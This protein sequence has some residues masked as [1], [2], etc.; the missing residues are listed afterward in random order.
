METLSFPLI[1]LESFIGILKPFALTVI[2]A[3][4]FVSGSR[5]SVDVVGVERGLHGSAQGEVRDFV[6]AQ[7][8]INAGLELVSP[9]QGLVIVPDAVVPG[10]RVAG[11]R[12]AGQEDLG[13]GAG[14]VDHE[15]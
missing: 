9:Q 8:G 15:I 12:S 3:H 1:T 4:V 14:D 7:F 6:P 11:R 2:G 5:G 13:W 10:A